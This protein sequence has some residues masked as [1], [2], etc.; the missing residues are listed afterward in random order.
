MPNDCYNHIIITTDSPSE[1]DDIIRNEFQ[2]QTPEGKYLYKDTVK[3]Q[4]RGQRGIRLRLWSAWSPEFEWLEGLLDKYPFMWIKNEWS[5]EGGMAGVWV[6]KL[7]EGEKDIKHLEWLDLS[8][9]AAYHYFSDS[10]AN[11]V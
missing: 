8:I 1:L 11:E 10:H 3:L 5:E 6:G 9:E 4:Q 7:F 2:Y